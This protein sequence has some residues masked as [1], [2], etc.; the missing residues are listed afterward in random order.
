MN[1]VN[2]PGLGKKDDLGHNILVYQNLL[3]KGKDQFN[4]EVALL[5]ERYTTKTS[6]VTKTK[7]AIEYK[8]PTVALHLYTI[9][10]Y[11]DQGVID[12]KLQETLKLCEAP[13]DPIFLRQ[14]FGEP[15][16]ADIPQLGE[17]YFYLKKIKMDE[18]DATEMI[19]RKLID[20]NE[21]KYSDFLNLS[22]IVTNPDY[23]NEDIKEQLDTFSGTI[24]YKYLM[25]YATN[26]KSQGK[27]PEFFRKEFKDRYKYFAE[28]IKK[29]AFLDAE[30]KDKKLKEDVRSLALK[31][32]YRLMALQG[33]EVM[34]E[35][36]VQLY[37][38][39]SICYLRLCNQKYMFE[40]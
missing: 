36:L 11:Y 19:L 31:T 7:Q 13:S 12:P 29:W 35:K 23:F 26:I 37:E 32:N 10:K 8:M 6:L 4:T 39:T 33:P 15:E 28:G 14:A 30:I 16:E 2:P 22:M 24:I 1:Y 9:G 18:D 25:Q 38:Y 17:F 27:F 5:P 21:T 20:Q 34:L 3:Y 40:G